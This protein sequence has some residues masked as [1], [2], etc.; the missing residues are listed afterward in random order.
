MKTNITVSLIITALF[1]TACEKEAVPIP[2][3]DL[4]TAA[5]MGDLT[6]IEQHIKAGSD[7]NKH[8]PSRGSTPLITATVFGPCTYGIKIGL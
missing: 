2:D 3:V 1:L 5:A 4:F 8:E 7:I 6:A